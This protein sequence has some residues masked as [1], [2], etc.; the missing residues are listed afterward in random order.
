MHILRKT[1]FSKE[2]QKNF[3]FFLRRNIECTPS[4]ANYTHD[5]KAQQRLGVAVQWSRRYNDVAMMTTFDRNTGRTTATPQN[6]NGNWT[7]ASNIHFTTPVLKKQKMLLSFALQ[8]SYQN[9]V[10]LASEMGQ[11]HPAS[12][13]R[14]LGADGQCK[15]DWNPSEHAQLS[16]LAN[17]RYRHITGDR[18]DFATINAADFDYGFSAIVDLPLSL[19]LSTS[20]VAYAH[21]GLRGAGDEHHAMHMER[22]ALAQAMPRPT[23]AGHQGIR[24]PG[25]TEKPIVPRRRARTNR[26]MAQRHTALR[27]DFPRLE[28]QRQPEEVNNWRADKPRRNRERIRAT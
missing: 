28:V 17:A 8:P 26:N 21:R 25:T 19:Q 10:D 18:P 14:S 15:A 4:G 24:H 27:H 7:I 22:G 12:I 11:A 5:L 1:F 13:V 2:Q 6:V 9:S 20:L 23:A 3:K 16:L